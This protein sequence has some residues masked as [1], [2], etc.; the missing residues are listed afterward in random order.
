M[1]TTQQ[2]RELNAWLDQYAVA[3]AE[4][5]QLA[6]AAV[7]SAYAEIDDWFNPSQT[8][9]AA[10]AAGQTLRAAQRVHSGL[11]SEFLAIVIEL[12]TG[13]RPT[14]STRR[15]PDYP[16]NAEV[17]DVYSRPVFEAREKLD[18]GFEQELAEIEAKVMAE[19][20]AETDL[21][22]TRRDTGLLVMESAGVTQYRR[23]VRP[24]L[25]KTGVCG[26]CIAAATKRYSIEDL[27]PIHTRC[28]CTVL[29]I[30]DGFD[31]GEIN[32]DDLEKVYAEIPAT[33]RQEL[34]TF[35]YK[36]QD[37]GELGPVLE[38]AAK[39]KDVP[40]AD[41][42]AAPDSAGAGASGPGDTVPPVASGGAD[43]DDPDAAVRA[44]Q[45]EARAA[46]PDATRAVTAVAAATGGAIERPGT[47]FKT[48][49]SIREK[50]QRFRHP[51]PPRYRLGKFNDALRYTIVY[52]DGAYW[53]QTRRVIGLFAEAGFAVTNDAGGWR[54]NY[55]GLNLT[56]QDPVG[57]QFEVQL[58]TRGSLDA[59]SATRD[60]Y[61]TWRALP[62]GSAERRETNR[63]IRTIMSR[64]A[65]PPGVPRV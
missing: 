52:D 22:M 60:L 58:H 35:R 27:L 36:V 30:V 63:Q 55:R 24:E 6:S 46:E 48:E 40:R 47:R 37:N 10:L 45:A 9:P 26:L 43:G 34:A 41:E 61:E 23:V 8:V 16:R 1:A 29:P 28:K 49:K 50:L 62:K 13:R 14:T 51:T 18:R 4:A 17:F 3:T 33:K 5:N 64:V 56:V 39:Q 53:S 32:A 57:R 59:A 25:S 11:M 38:P 15:V 42:P 7:W 54:S 2:Q 19:M 65:W 20:A 12:L 21:L 44:V 31:P